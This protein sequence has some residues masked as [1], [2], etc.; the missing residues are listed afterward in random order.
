MP[1]MKPASRL[2]HALVLFPVLLAACGAQP[3]TYSPQTVMPAIAPQVRAT[4]SAR[5]DGQFVIPAIPARHLSPENVRRVVNFWTDE[6]AGTI[7]VDPYDHY[8]YYVLGDDTALRYRV[9]VGEAG[10]NF[11][12]RAVVQRKSEWPRWTP[13]A[14]MLR[15]DPAL[16][17]PHRG[18]MPGGLENPLGAR[19]MY[20]YRNGRDTMYRIHG[21]YAPWSIGESISAGCIRMFNQDVIDLYERVGTGTRVRVLAEHERGYGTR[22]R[23]GMSLAADQSLLPSL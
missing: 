19:A 23:G 8:L 4:Y 18:G 12:G 5:D 2:R 9:G 15:E 13:T 22:P 20:L 10:R 17:E 6:P 14:N 7:V 3:I 21:T 16:Y 11:A 1:S